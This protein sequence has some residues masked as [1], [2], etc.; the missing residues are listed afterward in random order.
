MVSGHEGTSTIGTVERLREQFPLLGLDGGPEMVRKDTVLK[1]ATENGTT[2]ARITRTSMPQSGEQRLEAS[3]VWFIDQSNGLDLSFDLAGEYPL[4]QDTYSDEQN[5]R[6]RDLQAQLEALANGQFEPA[7]SY[8]EFP[9][10]I[11]D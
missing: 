1:R 9:G 6:I 10:A 5:A 8:Y 11:W 2:F 7:E 3:T 4:E